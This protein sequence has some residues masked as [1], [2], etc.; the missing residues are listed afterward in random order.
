MNKIQKLK[1]ERAAKLEAA[2]AITAQV[3][4]GEWTE[5]QNAE[6]EALMSEAAK[7]E[8]AIKTEEAREARAA[9]LAAEV[10]NLRTAPR[11]T[12]PDAI[13]GPDP[14]AAAEAIPATAHR[15]VS[16]RGFAGLPRAEA[17]AKAYRF[18][19]FAL[20][21][22]GRPRAIQYCR[23]SGLSVLGAT[24]NDRAELA[25]HTEGSNAAGGYLVPT[26]FD[27][28]LLR[29]VESYGV[30][31]RT[32]RQV[33]MLRETSSRTRRTGGL[34]AYF[35]GE[36][37]AGTESTMTFDRVNLT[38]KKLMALTTMSSELS[39]DMAINLGD[40][41]MSELALAFAYTEDN[42]GFNGDGTSTYGTIT[43]LR[44]KLAA[45][46]AGLSTAASG[47][48]TDWSKITLAKL[49]ALIGL[50]PSYATDL[51]WYCSNT[52]WGSTMLPLLGA[53][54]GA[55]VQELQNGRP[56]K[57]FRGYPVEI[58]QVMPKAASAAAIVCLFGDMSQA[59]DFGAGRGVTVKFS[60][61]AT[62]G[63]TNMFESD[64]IAVKGTQ[65][66]DINVHDVGDSSNAGPMVGLLTAS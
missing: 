46:T 42:C 34:T 5:E 17:E 51:R 54:G 41:L 39:E 7:L 35:V 37:T 3:G 60:E 8:A 19:M 62:I 48:A 32:A 15:Q 56:V 63:S 27:A 13:G 30:M 11:Q 2:Q 49:D 45:A 57:M 6:V 1:A 10:A 65:R 21:A 36:N 40:T 52:F 26:E 4:E 22:N 58:V 12:A 43:G 31:R 24:I 28:D 14:R 18:G 47:S 55:T 44:T 53:A 9:K 29:L 50:L 16:F 38:L 23:D 66:F 20:A 25:I 33:P 64:D 61:D 59:A